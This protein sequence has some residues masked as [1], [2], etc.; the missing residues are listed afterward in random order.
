MAKMAVF[1][2][3]KASLS[4]LDVIKKIADANRDSLGF[5]PRAAIRHGILNG[6]VIVAKI[7]RQVVGF[8]SY[9]HRKR[10]LDTKLYYKCVAAHFRRRGIGN[11]LVDAV[12]TESRSLGRLRLVLKCP[13]DLPSNG[14][15]KRYG[16]VLCGK[17]AGKLRRLNIW[18]LRLRSL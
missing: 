14:F 8:Q 12:V 6:E 17:E 16:F 9:H 11:R 1:H 2:I 15:H 5:L 10:D 3:A 18:E 7:G 4:D 13:E